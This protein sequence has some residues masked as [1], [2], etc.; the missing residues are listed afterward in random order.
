MAI[1]V[2]DTLRNEYGIRLPDDMS[3]AGY[4]NIAQAGWA[5]YSLTTVEQQFPVMIEI[6][7]QTLLRQIQADRVE[8][9]SVI[10]PSD[11]VVRGSAR[12]PPNLTIENTRVI[13]GLDETD[14]VETSV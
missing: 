1:S 6:A 14:S 4:D 3:V 7:V 11:L 10:L 13:A 12:I 9:E 8:P 5:A 2:I